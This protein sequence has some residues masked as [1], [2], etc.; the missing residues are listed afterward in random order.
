MNIDLNLYR[1]FYEVAKRGNI[2]KAAEELYISQPAVTQAIHS[3]EKQIGATLFIRAKK[4]VTLT[5]E[6]KVLFQF[7]ESGLNYIKNGE[8]KFKELMNIESGTLKIGAST[9][10]T[11]HV[12]LK[13]LDIF[14]ERYPNVSIS[15]VNNLTQDLVKLLREGSVDL[16]ILNLPTKEYKD[17]DVVPFLEVHDTFMVGKRKIDLLNKKLDLTKIKEDFIFQKSPSNTRLFLNNYLN[18]NNID[19]IPKYDV[20]S[21]NLVKDMTKMNL[22]IGYITR[23]FA[24]KELESGELFEIDYTPKIPSRNIG[25]ATL[26][27]TIPSFTTKKFIDIILKEK[28]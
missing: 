10:V 18:S 21:F 7:V 6:A 25:I 11:Q 27:N 4:G 28:I 8:N 1:I 13:Y 22:G 12:L 2:T 19:I 5:E 20:V 9:T 17:I 14:Q 23:E 3:L 24:I 15:I 16:L 26:S